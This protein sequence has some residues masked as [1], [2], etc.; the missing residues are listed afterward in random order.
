MDNVRTKKGSILPILKLKGKDYL[1]VAHR[2]QWLS[3]DH[4]NYDI[5]TEYHTITDEM[6]IVRAT[7]II[8]KDG[9]PVR[10]ATATKKETKKDFPDFIEKAETGSIG[11]ALAM[12]G[13]GTQMAISDLDEGSRLA[14]S[15]VTNPKEQVTQEAV[16]QEKPKTSTFRRAPAAKKEEVKETPQIVIEPSMSSPELESLTDEA[17]DGWS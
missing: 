2:L 10:S 6:A 5:R 1:Q 15:P 16:A 14:D 8:F 12:L 7:V 3:D 11:R 17:V 4:E 9:K 13:L